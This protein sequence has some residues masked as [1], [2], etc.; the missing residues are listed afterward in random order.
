VSNPLPVVDVAALEARIV[1][2]EARVE[3]LEA[4][5]SRLT[6]RDRIYWCG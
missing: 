5:R 2:L 6:R 3:R 1:A 4:E